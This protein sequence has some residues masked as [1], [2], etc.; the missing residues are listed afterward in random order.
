VIPHR[1][2]QLAV[3]LPLGV[4]TYGALFVFFGL[5]QSEREWVGR[6]IQRRL[7]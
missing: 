4:I 7:A 3:A 5:Q 1:S 2:L 6:F